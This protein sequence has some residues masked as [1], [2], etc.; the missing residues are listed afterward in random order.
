[1]FTVNLK[2]GGTRIQLIKLDIIKLTCATNVKFHTFAQK[3]CG[4]KDNFN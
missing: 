1:M 3:F 2:H 4:K